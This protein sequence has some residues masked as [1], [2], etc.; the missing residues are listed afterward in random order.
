[1][2]LPINEKEKDNQIV[3]ILNSIYND[4]RLSFENAI[5]KKLETVKI[6]VMLADFTV[7]ETNSFDPNAVLNYFFTKE[8]EIESLKKWNVVPVQLTKTDDLHRIFFQLSSELE[9][10]HFYIYMGIQF[11]ALLFY[12]ID[13]DVININKKIRKIEEENLNLKKEVSN[14]GNQIV[15]QELE[16]MGYSE[17]GDMELF[18]ELFAKQEL[19][20]S[21][22]GKANE[23]EDGFPLL[24]QN[25]KLIESL[26]KDLEDFTIETYQIIPN[27]IDSNKLMMGEEGLAFNV[28]FEII[29]NKKSRKKTSIIDFNKITE[30]DAIKIQQTFSD[31]INVFEKD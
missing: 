15:K 7:I 2:R 12:K 23:V 19:T 4:L 3:K 21:L 26:K 11:H 30:N 29:Q 9:K 17:I 5:K 20:D 16:K 31:L 18:E 1:M 22:S 24:K 14:R 25:A 28:D 10:Y 8:K 6:K 13:K 27:S